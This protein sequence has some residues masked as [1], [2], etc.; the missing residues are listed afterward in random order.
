MAT[1]IR[2]LSNQFKKLAKQLG[3]Q[4]KNPSQNMAKILWI[5][6][7][8]NCQLKKKRNR[9]YVTKHSFTFHLTCSNTFVPI[10]QG[11]FSGGQAEPSTNTDMYHG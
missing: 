7:K 1:G 11:G 10:L 6:F 3:P 9:E 8:K 5:L 2:I 4:T